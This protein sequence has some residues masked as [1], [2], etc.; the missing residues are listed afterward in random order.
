MVY[1]LCFMVFGRRGETVRASMAQ[2]EEDAGL[3]RRRGGDSLAQVLA[4]TQ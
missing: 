4:D 3:A 1:G 2:E